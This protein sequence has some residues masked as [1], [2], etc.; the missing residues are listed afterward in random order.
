[1]RRPRLRT[2]LAV[3]LPVLLIAAFVG[4]WT[5]DTAAADDGSLRNVELAGEDVGGLTEA[6]VAAVVA[7]Q[8]VA[9]SQV[10]VAI[11]T[12]SGEPLESTTADLGLSIDQE[13]TTE[14]V[15]DEGRG[16]NGFLRPFAWLRSFVAPYEVE[17]RYTL[18]EDQLAVALSRL[19]GDDARRPV[20]PTLI[21]SPDAVR[22]QGG[23]PG[24]ALDPEEVGEALLDAAEA[25]EDPITVTVEPQSREPQVSD[26]EAE[27]LA[28]QAEELT[29]QPFTATV[30][31][32]SATFG[33][34]EQRSWLGSTVSSDGIELTWDEERIQTVLQDSI[35]S[36]GEAEPQDARFTVEGGAVRLIPAVD[37]I[38]C[39]A[40]GSATAIA[41][42]VEAGEDAA[43]VQPLVVEPEL[44]TEEA[45]ALG[46]KE[47][48]GTTT[49][50]KGQPQVKSFT[51]YHDCCAA[52]VTNIHRIADLVRGALVLPGETFSVNGHVGPR[53]IEKGFVEAG[54][55][56][57]GEHVEEVGGGVSQFA[58]TLFNAAFFAGLPF[59]EYQA[60]SEHF[61]RYP[62]GR[63]ATM[64][65]EHP[66][67]QF[68]NDTPYGILIWTSYTDTSVTV[69]L[70]S[71]QHAY[72]QQTGQ[73]ESRSGGC[74]S[75][76]TERTITFPDGRTATDTVRA[77][78]RDPGVTRCG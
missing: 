73:S 10:E 45:E 37:G 27:E 40:E 16:G 59:G 2:L 70:Y 28:A 12:G 38:R 7:E 67:L 26:E 52:R 55:I 57:N 39:C 48:V 61:D 3:A 30:R 36:L 68:T 11:A 58:T 13:A 23:E 24:Q 75:V 19:E 71:T 69:T 32:K 64:G 49:E 66:D 6:E 44:T 8:A 76:T 62:Y 60:H 22:V 77:R 29:A 5:W 33:V 41:D 51:T 63:E 54:A 47:P 50:W 20:E 43:T 18:R 21:A 25:G 78:Y 14:A 35:G 9:F 15:L 4:G 42:A 46:I 74:T 56:A 65:Y 31:Q 1:V 72:G 17:P 53:T 34:P